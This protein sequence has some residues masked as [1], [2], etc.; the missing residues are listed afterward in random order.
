MVFFS[1]LHVFLPKRNSD[2]IPMVVELKRNRSAR[3][4]IRQIRD[5]SY[6]GALSGYAEIL[7]EGINYAKKSKKYTCRIEKYKE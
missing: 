5:K 2:A 1:L 3:A 4:A 7:L 6:T